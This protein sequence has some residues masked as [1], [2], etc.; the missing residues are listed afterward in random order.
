MSRH[1]FF[2]DED[3]TLSAY[4]Y[5]AGSAAVMFSIGDSEIRFEG[6]V[7]V[8]VNLAVRMI[9]ELHPHGQVT[10][11]GRNPDAQDPRIAAIADHTQKA[12]TMLEQAIASLDE[13]PG[14][15][16]RTP[17][18]FE[19]GDWFRVPPMMAWR[20]VKDLV[21]NHTVGDLNRTV[22]Y[23]FGGKEYRAGLRRDTTYPYMTDE[24][25][26]ASCDKEQTR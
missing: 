4:T 3:T 6:E 25:F 21:I 11:N 18:R 13:K 26:Q 5:E 19:V 2:P 20:Q 8:L 16:M 14:E 22:L 9:N 17:D 7:D 12:I 1:D 10:A 23:P 24:A 15:E